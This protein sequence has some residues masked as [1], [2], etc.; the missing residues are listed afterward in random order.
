M[1]TNKPLYTRGKVKIF[2]NNVKKSILFTRKLEVEDSVHVGYKVIIQLLNNT[3]QK[4]QNLKI[5]AL[6]T[7]DPAK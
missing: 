2:G 7:L 1:I 4:N 6:L 5:T 3:S